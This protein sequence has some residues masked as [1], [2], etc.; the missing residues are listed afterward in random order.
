M[1]MFDS[2]YVDCPNCGGSVEMQTKAGECYLERYTLDDAPAALLIDILNDPA[3]CRHCKSWFVLVSPEYPIGQP[4]QPP[5]PA[6]IAAKLREP[7]EGE[8]GTYARNPDYFRWW[9][10]PLSD[11]DIEGNAS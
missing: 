1:G 9:T 6:V 8:F 3:W 4:K 11:A 7:R 10:A 5:R 2:V